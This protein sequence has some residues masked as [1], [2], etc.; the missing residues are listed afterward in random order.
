MFDC[1]YTNLDRKLFIISYPF[2]KLNKQQRLVFSIIQ[3]S[4]QSAST[5]N[6]LYIFSFIHNI[7]SAICLLL[8]F[9]STA[10][11]SSQ[12]THCKFPHSID[13][14][15]GRTLSQHLAD[16]FFCLMELN[17]NG[18]RSPKKTPKKKQIYMYVYVYLQICM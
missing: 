8:V 15:S 18:R 14:R 9:P 17:P 4:V 13:G 10:R 2:I 7:H 12:S 1:H 3:L 6:C 5:C 11:P 16:V